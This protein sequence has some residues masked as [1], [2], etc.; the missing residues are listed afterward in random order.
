MC[1]ENEDPLKTAILDAFEAA[2]VASD[3]LYA[4]NNSWTPDSLLRREIAELD[5]RLDN[6]QLF[7]PRTLDRVYAVSQALSYASELE[8]V[9]EF[10]PDEHCMSG[11]TEHSFYTE[12]GRAIMKAY[13]DVVD[14]LCALR[15]VKDLLQA[16]E[17]A[18]TLRFQ[19][20][21]QFSAR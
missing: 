13:L 20:V 18:S 1:D 17:L 14:L 10:I 21:S 5:R 2:H 16:E 11:T 3:S 8:W 12:R 19:G 6:P 9:T 7:E 4:A 15:R